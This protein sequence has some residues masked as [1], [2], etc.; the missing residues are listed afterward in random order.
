MKSK[1]E[2]SP[3]WPPAQVL[4]TASSELYLHGVP[5]PTANHPELWLSHTRE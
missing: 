5:L 3:R 1:W 4:L 2:Y